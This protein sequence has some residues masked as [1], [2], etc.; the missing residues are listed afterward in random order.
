MDD[1][2]TCHGGALPFTVMDAATIVHR[3]AVSLVY[4]L[5]RDGDVSPAR[6]EALV[7]D[8]ESMP[9]AVAVHYECE[10]VARLAADVVDRLDTIAH[11]PIRVRRGPDRKSVV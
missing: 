3:P 6:L 5:L 8:L 10:H 4:R 9:P 2:W 7:G 1:R 11:P